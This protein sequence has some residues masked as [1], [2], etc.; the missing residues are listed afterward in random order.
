MG[1]ELVDNSNRIEVWLDL[2]VRF[3]TVDTGVVAY[4]GG[5]CYKRSDGE[6][7]SFNQGVPIPVSIP[8]MSTQEEWEAA[9]LAVLETQ[10][11]LDGLSLARVTLRFPKFIK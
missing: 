3:V 11:G 4:V 8:L 2:D 1:I 5:G 10:A 9:I 7:A 6:M